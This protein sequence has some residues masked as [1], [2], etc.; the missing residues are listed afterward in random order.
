VGTTALALTRLENNFIGS[1]Q[2]R[3]NSTLALVNNGTTTSGSIPTASQISLSHNAT[4]DVTGHTSGTWTLLNG[5]T[6]VTGGTTPANGGRILGAARIEGTLDL[7][8][9]AATGSGALR[10]QGGNLAIAGGATW[11]TNIT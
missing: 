7:T 11:R 4:L 1:F 10:Q 2:V 5:Q 8:G 6:L 3:D 9:E